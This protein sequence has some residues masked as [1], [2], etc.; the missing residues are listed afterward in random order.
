MCRGSGALVL[1]WRLKKLLVVMRY[2]FIGILSVFPLIM[3]LVWEK[4]GASSWKREKKIFREVLEFVQKSRTALTT[5]SKI[6]PH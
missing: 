6:P 4:C 5:K 1:G 3:A 2:F